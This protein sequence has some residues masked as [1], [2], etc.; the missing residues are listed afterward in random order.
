MKDLVVKSNIKKGSLKSWLRKV[1]WRTS[2]AVGVNGW[3]GKMVGSKNGVKKCNC[4]HKG[5]SGKIVG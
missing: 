2:W 3:V 4:K 5:N 1:V